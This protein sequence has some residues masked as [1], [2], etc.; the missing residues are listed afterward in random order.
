[1]NEAEP[2]ARAREELGYSR[3]WQLTAAA[4]MM[5][6]A[7]PYQ[8]VWSSIEGPLGESLGTTEFALGVVFTTYVVVMTVTQFPAG[9]YRDRFG[10]ARLAALAGL[11]AG[12]GYVG[13]GLATNILLLFFAYGIGSIGVGIIY[14]VAVNTA[15]KWFPDRPGLTTGIGT[16]AFGAGAA[17]FI[18][19]VRAFDGPNEL[20]M[21]LGGI[22]VLIAVGVI[23]GSAVL[24]DPPDGWLEKPVAADGGA[25]VR[26]GDYHWREMLHTWQFWVMYVSFVSVSAAGLMITARIVLFTE[27]LGLAAIIATI[28]ATA[29]PI[30]SGLG[31][32]LLGWLSDHIKRELTMAIAFLTC[33]VATLSLVAFGMAGMTVAY[34]VA[35]LVAIFCWSSQFSLFPSLVAE[36]YG[37]SMSSTN[38]ALVYS[39]KLWGGVFGGAVVGWMV[40][41]LGW[42]E[43]FLVGGGLAL[44][45]GI[46]SLFL[47]PPD[48]SESSS[49]V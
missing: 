46:A 16:M 45:A 12:A 23:G 43:T 25:M 22:G 1:M 24:R 14:T 34:I 31:R 9:W 37:T 11:L 10:P 27:Y 36:Y 35:V 8:Y 48:G 21:V 41:G 13:T 32:L 28:A 4:V 3:W 17:V 18:P 49:S 39:G 44:F 29:L 2:A 33:G 38:Y 42:E 19:V 6:L 40:V 26:G 7:S 15:I 30:A 47:R 20:P 5:M